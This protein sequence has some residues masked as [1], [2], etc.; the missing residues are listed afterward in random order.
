M[1]IIERRALLDN[2]PVGTAATHLLQL[3][4]IWWNSQYDPRAPEEK[5]SKM[6]ETLDKIRQDVEQHPAMEVHLGEIRHHV[7][8]TG[9]DR[10][11]FCV[12]WINGKRWEGDL[13]EKRE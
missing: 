4:A 12:I 10:M 9:V 8:P 6:D 2:V 1:E 3:G 11:R 5:E 13:M 7:A